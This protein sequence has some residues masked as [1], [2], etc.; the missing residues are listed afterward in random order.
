MPA[1]EFTAKIKDTKAAESDNAVFQCVLSAPLN[2]ITWS[3]QDSSLEH[4][5]KYDI[6]VSEDKLIHMLKVKDCNLADNGT[7]YAIAGIASSSAL[8]TVEG[9]T[10]STCYL[11]SMLFFSKCFI[12]FSLILAVFCNSANQCL[13]TSTRAGDEQDLMKLAL[14]PRGALQNQKE[15]LEATRRAPAEKDGADTA[16]RADTADGTRDGDGGKTDG[17]D[18]EGDE[19]ST[20]LLGA[21]DDQKNAGD[22]K[23]EVLVPDTITGIIATWILRRINNVPL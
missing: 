4:G 11:N 22:K 2:R 3:K 15:N 13:G 23:K 1:V 5:G 18:G 14:E 17:H 9:G 16:T 8:L 20:N 19:K 10:S 12:Y 21:G 7:Y 6:T